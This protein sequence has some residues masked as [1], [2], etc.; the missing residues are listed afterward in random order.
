MP[1]EIVAVQMMRFYG[2]S[3]YSYYF[4]VDVVTGVAVAKY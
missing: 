3:F 2:L 1:W 4:S